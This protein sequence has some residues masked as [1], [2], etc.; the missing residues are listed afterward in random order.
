MSFAYD[1]A[2]TVGDHA[3][4]KMID[5]RARDFYMTD[6]DCPI[7]WEPSGY[8]FLSPCLQELDIMR[9]ILTDQEFTAWSTAFLPALSQ[10][11]FSL[12][13]AEVKDRL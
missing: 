6:A 5:D 7:S 3:L 12:V 10:T 13:P 1:Y 8:D 2:R 9:K 4:A 11:N